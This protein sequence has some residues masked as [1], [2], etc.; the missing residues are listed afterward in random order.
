[1]EE[2]CVWLVVG[3]EGGGEMDGGD[4]QETGGYVAAMGYCFIWIRRFD[5]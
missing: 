2:E 3:A 1:M 5:V 4:A